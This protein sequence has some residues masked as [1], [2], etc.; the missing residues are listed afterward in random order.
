ML[1]QVK[2][3]LL[4]KQ[5]SYF[6]KTGHLRFEDFPVDFMKVKTIAKEIPR[7]RDLWRSSPFLKK[8]ILRSFGPIAL[9]LMK[10]ASLHLGC[11]QWIEQ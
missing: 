6:Q 10:K 3:S 4:A 5:F 11:D 8:L 7:N 2:T 1:I 9:E